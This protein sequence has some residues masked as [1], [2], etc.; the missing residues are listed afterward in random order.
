MME[1]NSG[2]LGI[3]RLPLI[4]PEQQELLGIVVTMGK[5][6]AT[7]QSLRVRSLARSMFALWA[8]LAAEGETVAMA[9]RARQVHRAVIFK[10]T[11]AALRPRETKVSRAAKAERPGFPEPPGVAEIWMSGYRLVPQHRLS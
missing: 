7:S 8:E 5:T 3:S 10:P 2:L 1:S 11:S 4:N 9:Q 6:Q